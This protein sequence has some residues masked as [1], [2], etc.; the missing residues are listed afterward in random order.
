MT[1][2]SVVVCGPWGCALSTVVSV[3]EMAAYSTICSQRL[4]AVCQC[5]EWTRPSTTVINSLLSHIYSP[6]LSERCSACGRAR[7]STCFRPSRKLETLSLCSQHTLGHKALQLPIGGRRRES[8][9]HGI[10]YPREARSFEVFAAM[11]AICIELR[12]TEPGPLSL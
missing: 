8:A 1:N 7:R 2:H 3:S 4:D 12:E 9:G 6:H 5:L 11:T 10:F